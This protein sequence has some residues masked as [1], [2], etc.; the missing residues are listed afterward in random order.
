MEL[1]DLRVQ[2]DRIDEQLVKLFVQRMEV[3]AQVA[4]YKKAH[5]LPIFVPA[6]EQEKLEDVAQQAGPEMAD[7]TTALY[8]AIFELSRSYQ[9]K[10]TQED[11]R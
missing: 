9:R 5:Q 6:R 11:A 4:A 7:Y 10:L 1:K 8:A 2:I 3:C